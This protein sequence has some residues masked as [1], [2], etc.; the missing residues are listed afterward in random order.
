MAGARTLALR[1]RLRAAVENDV[2]GAIADLR[3]ALDVLPAAHPEVVRLACDLV[4]VARAGGRSEVS[5]SALERA[6]SAVADPPVSTR[7]AERLQALLVSS[8]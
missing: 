8:P 3:R 4:E 7:Q 6:K 2:D 1:A 5:A